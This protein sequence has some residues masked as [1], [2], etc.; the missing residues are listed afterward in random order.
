MKK[1]PMSIG[2]IRNGYSSRE[3][4]ILEDPADYKGVFSITVDKYADKV[5][6]TEECDGYFFCE[7]SG[8]EA[9]AMLQKCITYIRYMYG[10]TLDD[11]N[12]L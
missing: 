6:F 9:I 10:G 7:L 5:T 1:L 12:Q 4:L 8:V 2:N 3:G 11:T